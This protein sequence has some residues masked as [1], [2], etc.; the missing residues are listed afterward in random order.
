MRQAQLFPLIQAN[1]C[2]QHRQQRQK[3]IGG[4]QVT[5]PPVADHPRLVSITGAP[6]AFCQRG[7]ASIQNLNQPLHAK[8]HHFQRQWAAQILLRCRGATNVV[9]PVAVPQGQPLGND[10]RFLLGRQRLW[11]HQAVNRQRAQ[12]G[13]G[14]NHAVGV[15]HSIPVSITETDR[16]DPIQGGLSGG[17]HWR[18]KSGSL[19]LVA[20]KINVADSAVNPT[21]GNHP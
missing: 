21:K 2:G 20:I 9:W 1:G 11:Q 3:G 14:R 6:Q 19:L 10:R 18:H 13:Q 16:M 15:A 4:A 8:G 12:V 17:R 7:A 5:L